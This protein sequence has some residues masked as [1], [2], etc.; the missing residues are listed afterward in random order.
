MARAR[1]HSLLVRLLDYSASLDRASSF[2]VM[3]VAIFTFVLLYVFTVQ[4][5]EGFLHRHFN[6]V[7]A[8]AVAV[9]PAEGSVVVQIRERLHQATQQSP[10]ARVGDV[11]VAVLVLGADGSFISAGG[12][13]LPPPTPRTDEAV[14]S[15]AERVLPVTAALSVSVPHNALLANAVLVFYGVLLVTG[16]FFYNRVLA[17][18]EA[19]RMAEAVALRDAAA[20][21]ARSIDR[22][23][24]SVRQRLMT[25]EP[26]EHEHAD[27]I[28]AL[29]AE[30]EALQQKLGALIEREDELRGRAAQAIELDQERQALEELLDEAQ[31]DLNNKDD[32]I[33]QLQRRLKRA[34]KEAGE[35]VRSRQVESL[36]R[37]LRTLYKNVEIDDRALQDLVGL[38]D[39]IMKLRAE[40]SIQ[41]LSA[42]AENAGVR[43][44]V[45][46]LPPHL[47]I[48]ELGFAGKGRIYYSR[49]RQRRFRV[50]TIGAKNT[51]KTDLEYLS[52]LARSE[53]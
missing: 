30:R 14:L 1:T 21:R 44:K 34:S 15:E 37:R 27:E 7:I 36:T 24:A 29:R 52:R 19:K 8:E 13:A 51:Q 32:E 45:G 6:D 39:E 40:E 42:E 2:R 17:R 10:W 3:Y 20:E 53:M 48:F 38:R 47:S 26:A 5:A 35:A 49:G 22:E 31:R 16:L 46:G 9:D 4:G 18:R 50:L 11:R 43:R 23:I 12:R 41:R 33:Q 25:L 28:R